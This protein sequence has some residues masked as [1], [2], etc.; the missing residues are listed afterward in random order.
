[1]TALANPKTAAAPAHHAGLE[2]KQ[3]D[4][5]AASHSANCRQPSFSSGKTGSNPFGSGLTLVDRAHIPADRTPQIT[6]IKAKPMAIQ[7]L[8]CRNG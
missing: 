3:P 8:T 6:A 4:L 2:L 7:G 1:M 5:F